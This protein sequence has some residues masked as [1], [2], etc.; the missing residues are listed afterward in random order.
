MPYH[1]RIWPSS[2][3]QQTLGELYAFNVDEETLR[4]RFVQP[5]EAGGSITWNGRTIDVD[6]IATIHIAAMDATLPSPP[7]TSLDE[8]EHFVPA[9]V[10]RT[11]LW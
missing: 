5:Y 3:R 6:D 8:Y 11:L 2:T 1:V 4:T 10:H 7:D 9:P